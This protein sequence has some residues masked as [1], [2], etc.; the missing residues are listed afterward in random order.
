M[1]VTEQPADEPPTHSMLAEDPDDPEPSEP[2]RVPS[3]VPTPRPQGWFSTSMPQAPSALSPASQVSGSGG[4]AGT[5]R[6]GLF[7]DLPFRA[8]A[9]VSGWVVAVGAGL[10]IVAFLLPW[11][12]VGVAGT[13]LDPGYLGRWGLANPSYLLLVAAAVATF[14][15]ATIPNR[16]PFTASAIAVPILVGGFM[17]GLGWSYV[18]GPYGTGPGVDAMSLGAILMVVGGILELRPGRIA[19][20]GGVAAPRASASTEGSDT[21]AS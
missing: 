11:A 4:G 20:I 14:L 19:R 9:D 3:T 16:V 12:A 5:T 2:Y 7:S 6:A 21:P 18:T 10:A 15:L 1:E 8:P 13:N 17:L